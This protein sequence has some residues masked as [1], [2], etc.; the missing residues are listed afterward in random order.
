LPAHH[1]KAVAY[2]TKDK[3]VQTASWSVTGFVGV[4]TIEV[5]LDELSDTDNYLPLPAMQIGD[6]INPLTMTDFENLIGRYTWI[7]ASVTE[8]T[9]GSIELVTLGY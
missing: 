5:T 1:K 8:F 7:R 4:I 6:G 3:N 9:A 2:Y